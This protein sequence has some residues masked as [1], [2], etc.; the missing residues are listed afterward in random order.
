MS[1]CPARNVVCDKCRVKG[2]Y[3]RT[4]IK[5]KDCQ[6]WG[7]GSDKS[8]HC[9]Q[10]DKTETVGISMDD[11]SKGFVMSELAHITHKADICLATVG[12]KKGRTI[13]LT[14][15][16]FSENFGWI[17]QPSAPHP[18]LSLITSACP[19]DQAQFGHPISDMSSMTSCV[20]ISVCDT[21][22][23]SAAIPPGAAYKVGY[24][25]KGL[26]PSDLQDEW[27]W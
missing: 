27:G 14:H 8:K 19:E 20:Q 13:P 15:H 10:G 9:K 1:E 22:C 5:C 2:H 12:S 3:T 6:Q 16:I 4:C 18:T 23:M 24:S 7:H 25:R 26:H 21:G 17:E 11:N